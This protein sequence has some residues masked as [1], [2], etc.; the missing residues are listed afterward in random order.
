M[1][2]IVHL[3]KPPQRIAHYLRIGYREHVLADR[4]RAEG[5]FSQQGFIF[6]ACY[7]DA[8]IDLINDLR[9]EGRELILDT[10]IA[11]QSVLGRFSGT[12]GDAPWARKESPLESGDFKPGTNRSIVEPIARFA[13][14]KSFHTILSPTHYLG[15]DQLYWFEIDRLSC[16]ALRVALDREGGEAIGIKYALILDNAQI[17]AA[18]L[19]RK[20]V[21]GLQGLP[22][23]AL[24]LRVAGF[25]VDATGA[26]VDKMAR[27]VLE[28]HELGIPVVMDRVGGLTALA[29]ASF[30][31][32]SG[33]TNGLKGKDKFQ[34][35]GWLKPRT[36]GGGGN[37]RA[38]FIAGLD[39]RMKVAKMKALF[40]ASATARSVYGC[41]ETSCCSSID[42]MLR[43]P[44]AH[45]LG[46]QERSVSDLSQVPEARR[47]DYF[48]DNYVDGMRSKADRS[49][50][51][52]KA[53]D[54]FLK[55]AEIAATRLNRMKDALEQTSKRI[56]QIPFAVEAILP[57]GVATQ[58]PINRTRT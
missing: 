46:E 36:S 17:K 16:E 32:A 45:H 19:V 52:K 21:A 25:G 13:I 48:L 42:A 10:N 15:G 2:N 57:S 58:T 6:D 29:L 28:F 49:R 47:P 14:S 4:M 56:G 24:W 26:G 50:R 7:V 33:Y 20:I 35:S 44:E 9:G 30:G 51:L 12:V 55:T 27:A 54:D 11:E 5:Q 18:E 23:D 39:R 34:T 43:E 1:S 41:R 8:Q 22:I 31:V 37:D 53:P 3:H 40:A 38:V